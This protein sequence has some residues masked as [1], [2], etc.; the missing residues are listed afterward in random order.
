M[1]QAHIIQDFK[2]APFLTYSDED[3]QTLARSRTPG[4][5]T[6]PSKSS[7]QAGLSPEAALQVYEGLLLADSY[8][9]D[10]GAGAKDVIKQAYAHLE[11]VLQQAWQSRNPTL[12]YQSAYEL[13]IAAS[14]IEKESA[15]VSER[16]LI[17]G[18]I[19][20]RLRKHM[21]LQ[22]DPTVIYAL[23]TS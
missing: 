17:S 16:R 10:A 6:I 21:P 8:S 7:V 1:T 23:G 15:L 11:T 12:P 13:L 19:V 9:Y 2:T 4:I 3:W 5:F 20:N 22:M 14:I 18:V